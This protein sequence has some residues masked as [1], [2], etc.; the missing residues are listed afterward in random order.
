[1]SLAQDLRDAVRGFRRNPG[2]TATV[3]LTLGLGIGATTAI[4]SGVNTVFLRALPFPDSDRLVRIRNYSLSAAGGRNRY[5]VTPRNFA[6]LADESRSLSALVALVA[7]TA[8]L[9]GGER[10]QRVQ[11]VLASRGWAPV[12][13]VGP[14]EGRL[15]A[16]DEYRAGEASHVALVGR[17]L[18]E[19]RFGGTRRAI[20][21]ELL[22]DGERYTIVGVM[23]ARFAFPYDAEIWVPAAPDPHEGRGGSLAV[24]GRLAPGASL[25]GVRA[26]I[27]TVADRLEAAYPGTNTGVGFDAEPI[28]ASFMDGEDRIVMALLAA[29]GCLLLMACANV[30]NL[31]LARGVAREREQAMRAALGAGRGRQFRQLLVESVVLSLAGGAAGLL[32]AA[33]LAGSLGSLVPDVL[34]RQLDLSGAS[35][36]WRVLGFALAASMASGVLFGL[37]PA[38]TTSRRDVQELLRDGAR[39]GGGVRGR[40]LLGAFVSSEIAIAVALLVAAAVMVQNFAR[41]DRAGVGFDTGDLVTLRVSLEGP[42]YADGSNRAAFV[43]GVLDELDATPGVQAAAA[44]TVNPLC[45]GD[46]GAGISV[47]GLTPPPDAPRLV[48]AHQYVTPGFFAAMGIPLV[49]GRDFTGRDR[50][51]SEPVAIVDERFARRFW[52]GEDPIGKRIKRG[53]PDDGFPWM[54]VVGVAAPIRDSS[55]YSEAWYLPY[56]QSPLG[57][58]AADLHVMVRA[59]AVTPALV[60]AAGRAVSRVDPGSAVYGVT[61]MDALGTE[62]L[63]PDRLGALVSGLMGAFGMLL[64]A[65]GVYGVMAFGVSRRRREIGLRVALGARRGQVL[66]MVLGQG[67][68]LALPGV[69]AG[70]VG[71]VVLSRLFG[72][73][74]FGARAPDAGVYALVVGAL[75]AV[76]IAATFVPARRASNVDP[77]ESLRAE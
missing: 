68:R 40:R 47:E 13:G 58:S 9:E 52:P 37:V 73:V 19:Q 42:R 72:A 41:L 53:L 60:E 17:A 45:C 61:T 38:W 15:F 57:P 50:E 12:L 51:G 74:V 36:D 7:R 76:A 33:W 22:V 35:I 6:A 4:F 69:A 16:P 71:A 67:L 25:D 44:T 14:I 46:W 5:G 20:G 8:T 34:S 21:G 48:V 65:L 30:A 31:L 11:V 39:T 18:A 56:L 2:F 26:E 75:T 55:D 49:A 3:I 64:A 32:L 23:P 10:P 66:A 59:A 77:M 28:R 1:M 70:V 29:V 63:S 24:F 62:R 27:E 54:R 43:T